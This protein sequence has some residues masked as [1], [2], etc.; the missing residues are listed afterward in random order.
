MA[1]FTLKEPNGKDS[2]LI[3]LTYYFDGKRFKYST[4]QKIKPSDWNPEKQ[5]PRRDYD[6]QKE[7]SFMLKR[8]GTAVEDIHRRILNNGEIPSVGILKR[9]MD[10]FTQKI[11]RE[12]FVQFI[13]RYIL[14]CK[15]KNSSLTIFKTVLKHLKAYPGAKN[16]DDVNAQWLVNYTNYLEGKGFSANYIGKN[17]ST[18]K[19][20][21]N[22][23]VEQKLTS[24]TAYKSTRYSRPSEEVESIYLTNDELVAM[25]QKKMTNSK[26]R[27]MDLFLVGAFT[28]LRF[29][30]IRRLTEE[31]VTG[32]FIRI[33]HI[34][35]GET[36]VIPLH[37]I[38]KEIF[39]K[40]DNRFPEA[41]SNQKMNDALKLIGRGCGIKD[42]VVK[43]R[44]KGGKRTS[45]T[46]EKW[47][48]ITTHTARR[49][50][51]TN[52]YLAGIPSI[53]IMRITG[54]R[55]E[56]SFMKYIRISQEEN[57]LFMQNHPYFQRPVID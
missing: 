14:E 51:A 7:L 34:K 40:Y 27:V 2:T 54:H 35:T 21:F 12:S 10:L 33:R 18:L 49:S 36:V 23:A 19:Q 50:A 17:I 31:N 43:S 45:Q 1:K 25:Y 20:F 47:E 13:D 57:A 38:V 42:M 4:G 52:M 26:E 5:Q 55:T 46:F 6:G 39:E 44:T 56:K 48:L 15:K 53:S 28:A 9:E 16:F 30:D 22:E 24:N 41:I 8:M 3:Y 29:S 37:W 11:S 32:G